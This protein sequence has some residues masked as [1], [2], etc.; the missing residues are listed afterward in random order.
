MKSTR[1]S[2]NSPGLTRAFM[3]VLLAAVMIAGSV[4][5]LV[6]AVRGAGSLNPDRPANTARP[7]IE[8]LQGRVTQ[9]KQRSRSKKVLARA[10]R[11]RLFY[12][13]LTASTP[14]EA[15]TRLADIRADRLRRASQAGDGQWLRPRPT[16]I[17]FAP[18]A[19]PQVTGMVDHEE[20]EHLISG[21]SLSPAR[22]E[23]YLGE[24]EPCQTQEEQDEFEMF[25]EEAL[26]EVASIE[27]EYYQSDSDYN[28]YCSEFPWN[29][30][31]APDGRMV[32]SPMAGPN[33]VEC[34][35]CAEQANQAVTEIVATG[36]AALLA[37]GKLDE[38]KQ[39]A[40]YMSKYTVLALRATVG[41]GIITAA[42][43]TG[44][45][46]AC[47]IDT[48]FFTDPFEPSVASL[49]YNPLLG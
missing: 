27:D 36:I 19:T 8:T 14:E 46:T 42:F 28:D 15:R 9:L 47:V 5:N 31:T 35:G 37:A 30:S 41:A 43:W 20:A 18:P 17:P 26:Y 40:K 7:S 1:G 11:M 24:E 2:K 25:V 38:A 12:D 34:A 44:Y 32:P 6:A 39:A 49:R 21:P 4:P 29:C 23:C 45:F 10:E 16:R 13:Y 33:A 22:S 3:S 48:L